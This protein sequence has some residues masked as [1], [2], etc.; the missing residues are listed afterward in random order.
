MSIGWRCLAL[1]SGLLSVFSSAHATT[2]KID[3]SNQSV[4]AEMRALPVRVVG[5]VQV[6]ELPPPLPTGAASYV[7]EWPGVYF[8]TTF[9]GERIALKFNDS[10]HEYRLIVDRTPP[11]ALVRP[12]TAEVVI[13]GLARTRHSVRLEKV[14]ESFGVRG[15]FQG[16]YAPATAIAKPTRSQA[17]QIEFIGPSGM[18]G[19]GDRSL[20]PNCTFEELHA[21]T[22]SQQAYT[23]LVAKGLGADYQINAV[24]GHGLI[25]NVKTVRSDPGLLA[26]YPFT[27]LDRTVPYSDPNWRP[28]IIDISAFGDFA[29]DLDPGEPW[30]NSD[31]LIADW[32]RSFGLLISELHRRSPGA[33]ILVEWPNEAG[34]KVEYRRPFDDAKKEIIAAARRV[35]V[36]TIL[37]PP[38]FHGPQE[39]TGCDR[40][41]NLKDQRAI[42][43]WMTGYINDHPDL[44]SGQK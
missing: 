1:L 15:T 43:N 27:F 19:F 39:Q 30:K 29:D 22:D 35:G 13:D 5:R 3:R 18:T 6:V 44:W 33:A 31:E 10:W 42:A 21:T 7:H 17:R 34:F 9:V 23:A 37:F 28:Q 2:L 12:G 38:F 26:L 25:R 24:S 32:A 14:S 16:F 8:E 36:R 40:H 41:G 11:I 4:T 20:T